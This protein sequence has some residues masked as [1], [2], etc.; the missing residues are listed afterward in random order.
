MGNRMGYAI[1]FLNVLFFLIVFHLFEKTELSFFSWKLYFLLACLLLQIILM[2]VFW[3]M[4]KNVY[5]LAGA[6]GFFLLLVCAY[7]G[8]QSS[9]RAFNSCV[10]GSEELRLQ[11]VKFKNEN[12]KLPNSI[13]DLD[14][15]FI[16]GA[17]YLN[18]LLIQYFKTDDDFSLKFSDSIVQFQ[19]SY[20]SPMEAKK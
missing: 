14:P 4:N 1:I 3:R 2:V 6:L 9:G 12:G 17:R 15:K 16:C 8:L 11:I 13:N 20:A 10:S 18:P 19:G 7:L 5:V